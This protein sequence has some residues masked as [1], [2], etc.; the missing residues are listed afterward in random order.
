MPMSGIVP[1]PVISLL[2]IGIQIRRFIS[3]F[4]DMKRKFIKIKLANLTKS[5]PDERKMKKLKCNNSSPQPTLSTS[6]QDFESIFARLVGDISDEVH[7][8]PSV[9][10]WLTKSLNHNTLGGKCNRGLSVIDTTSILLGRPLTSQEFFDTAAL[11]WMIELFQAFM[12]VT[13]DIMDGSETRRGQLCW[14]RVP[15][16]SLIA[17][18]DA[19]MLESGIYILLKKYFKKH[20]SY[21]D[22]ME[23]FHEISYK[24]EVGQAC[25]LITAAP[26]AKLQSYDMEQYLFI[27]THKT[28]YY[29]FY[30]PVALALM[31]TQRAT[32]DNLDTTKHITLK[33]GE[34]FQ[35][36]DDY[37]DAFAD[38]KVLGKI[39]TD[40]V[41]NKCSW[42]VLQSLARCSA[43]QMEI[44][45]VNYGRQNGKAE[46]AVKNLYRQLEL[47]VVYEKYADDVAA[48]LEKKIEHINETQGLRKEAFFAFLK[49]IHKRSK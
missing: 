22:M 31:Y 48:E 26:G 9:L 49:K 25:D 19:C 28:A 38:P 30:L 44:L 16:V 4:V 6:I 27:V 5:E 33:M 24:T 7:L 32:V 13:D 42:L 37:L 3:Y 29:S 20:P 18:N 47:N 45:K 12:L 10:E 41:D 15:G 1:F 2:I 36:Q 35:V 23:L 40:I 8:P 46:A 21:V 17:I 39:G 43:E 34:Y 11:G 14:Y